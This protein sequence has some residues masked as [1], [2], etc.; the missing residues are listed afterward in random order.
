MKKIAFIVFVVTLAIGSILAAKSSFGSFKINFGGVK[1]SGTPRT[2]TRNI[3]GFEAIEAGGAVNVEVSVQKDFSVEV[4]AD[5]NLLEYIKTETRGNTLRIYSQGKISPRSRI[6]VKISMPEINSVEISGASNA[7]VSNVNSD[8]IKL[9]ASGASKIKIEGVAKN[10]E[11][12]AS[13]AS[14]IDAEALKVESADVE[15]NGASKTIVTAINELKAD[16]SGAS[17]IY[18]M[19]EPKDVKSKSS[20]ASSVKKK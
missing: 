16:A 3:S 2:E 13:G 18:Y 9:E 5:D 10:L 1:G 15:A 11:S 8:S 14:A 7:I 17:T 6:N 20:G 19:G 4:E 12:E